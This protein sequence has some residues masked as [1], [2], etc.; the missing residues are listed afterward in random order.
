MNAA[1]SLCRHD[2]VMRL[3]LTGAPSPAAGTTTAAAV[4]F[5]TAV[6]D[7]PHL[8]D[9]E[10]ALM[11]EWLDRAISPAPT[12]RASTLPLSGQRPVERDELVVLGTLTDSSRRGFKYRFTPVNPVNRAR[13]LS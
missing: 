8:T 11:S 10:R 1:G 5:R 7:L 6:P 2:A 9:T 3:I 4:A 12:H 13:M